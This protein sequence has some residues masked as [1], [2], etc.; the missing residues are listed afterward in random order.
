MDK[1]NDWQQLLERDIDFV[2]ALGDSRIVPKSVLSKHYVIGNHGAILP[3][4]QGAAS[5]VWGRMINSGT[6]GIS[7][8]ELGEVIDSGRI[9]ATKEFTYD[10]NCTMEEFV[11]KADDQTIEAL[12]D[13]LNGNSEPKENSM[14]NI[15]IS[16][17]TDSGFAVQLLKDCLGSGNNIYLPPR[18]IQDSKINED[19]A[20]SFV[21]S[22]KK[23]NSCPY[24]SWN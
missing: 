4:V 10:K 22:F 1:T 12:F 15:K 11:D 23:A 5:L 3:N 8:M 18:N 21:E 13:F 9:L 19:W 16:K 7:I 24:P 17:H 6:W 20:A 2:I 14:W